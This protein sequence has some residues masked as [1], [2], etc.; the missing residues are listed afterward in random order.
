M[1]SNYGVFKGLLQIVSILVMSALGQKQTWVSP[2]RQPLDLFVPIIRTPWSPKNS[3]PCFSNVISI[4]L[5]F[6]ACIGSLPPAFSARAI[7]ECETPHLLASSRADHPRNARAARIWAP[8]TVGFNQKLNGQT[9][10]LRLR[11]MQLTG[12]LLFHLSKVT[13]GAL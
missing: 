2:L 11:C 3:I 4:K 12:P 9:A 13:I 1:S 10:G 7:A 6:L 8:V 5:R